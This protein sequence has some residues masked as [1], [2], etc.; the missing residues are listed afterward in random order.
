MSLLFVCVPGFSF[1]QVILSPSC[2]SEDKDVNK[3]FGFIDDYI[4]IKGQ[5]S[6]VPDIFFGHFDRPFFAETAMRYK[7]FFLPAQ[8]GR[9]IARARVFPLAY[10]AEIEVEGGEMLP[11]D[12]AQVFGTILTKYLET[13]GK[14][15]GAIGLMKGRGVTYIR[16]EGGNYVIENVVPVTVE[17]TQVMIETETGLPAV[18]E[19]DLVAAPTG[20]PSGDAV[21]F[22][23]TT[24]NADPAPREPGRAGR[25]KP[26]L[27]K[28]HV[29]LTK[30][31]VA[32]KR[33]GLDLQVAPAH[34]P[35]N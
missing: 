34:P 17:K 11:L 19:S 21:P 32:A 23:D 27:W 35:T 33:G 9:V 10:A 24:N 14:T 26:N 29:L 25:Q 22:E 7:N 3:F 16:V 12:D 30:L 1:D 15:V 8:P 28:K 6:H 18:A 13:D 31:V 20:E 5:C 4:K 2:S